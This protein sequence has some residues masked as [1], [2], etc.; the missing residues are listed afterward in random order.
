MTFGYPHAFEAPLDRFGVGRTRK[1]W[2]TVLFLPPALAAELPFAAH[3]RLR[4]EGE[5]AEL[6]VEG[7]W[8]PT[9]DGRRYF[10]VSP[11]VL[12]QAELAIGDMAEMRFRIAD[13]NAVD[14][15]PELTAGLSGDPVADAAWVTLTPGGRRGFAHLVHG[16]KSPE[17]RARRVAEVL[18]ALRDGARSPQKKRA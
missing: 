1:I 12:K 2:Y 10:M 6:P 18:A 16:A 14:V 4:V 17:T 9:G 8:M 7:A 11:R 13:Q 15:P 5:I 3:P